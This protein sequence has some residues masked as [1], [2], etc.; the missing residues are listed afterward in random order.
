LKDIDTIEFL[1]HFSHLRLTLKSVKISSLK[2]KIE[3]LKTNVFLCD[4]KI[5]QFKT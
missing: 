4:F 5:N 3:D 2:P 1:K